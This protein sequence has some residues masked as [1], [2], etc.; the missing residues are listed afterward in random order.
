MLVARPD[1]LFESNFEERLKGLDAGAEMGPR[2]T[3]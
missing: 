1:G 3:A 2:L